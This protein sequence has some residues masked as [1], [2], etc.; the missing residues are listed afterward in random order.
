MKS[1]GIL[2]ES[3]GN[4][5]RQRVNPDAFFSTG[6]EH[7]LQTDKKKII[8]RALDENRDCLMEHECKELL[9]SIGIKTA[10][11]IIAESED[12]A[13]EKSRRIGYP[14]A[15]KI[16][17]P[18]VTHKSDGGGVKLNVEN[19]EG[20]RKAYHEI[21][22][23][24]RHC[25]VIGVS[26]QKMADPGLEAIIGVTRDPGFGPVLMF[27]LG[28]VFV[29]VLKD[30]TFRILPIDE[31][32]AAEM[33][34]EIKGSP[35]L[36]GY[37]GHAADI[38][39]LKGL[40][41]KISRLI[42]EHPEIRELD[43]NPVFLYPSGC[44]AVDARIYVDDLQMES[45]EAVS[46]GSGVSYDFFYPRSI[47]V[48]GATDSIGKL[49]YNVFHNLIHHG[50][51][52]N[53][54]PINPK[55]ETV[56]GVKAYKSILD[57]ED[58]VDT[59]IV[60]VPAGTVPQAIEDCCTKGIKYLVIETAGFA[61]I[62]EEGKQ[63]QARIKE[64]IRERGCRLLGPNCSGVINTHHNMVQSIGILDTL[65]KG[66]VGLIAQA[67]VY[68]AGILAGLRH[69]LDFGIVATIGNKMDISETDILEFMGDDKH[70][71][72][73]AMYMEDVTSGKRF[74]NV[75]SRVSQRKPVVVLKTGRTEAGKKAV[76][77]HT[78]SLA[79]NDEINSAAFRQSGIIR[80]RDNEH[81][82]ALMR[83]FSKQPLPKGPGVLVIT[84]TG[85]LGVAATD[86]LYLNN[87][88]LSRF[89]PYLK[90]RL[91]SILPDYL[92][93]QNPV[94]CSFSMTPEQLKS[95]IEIGI[96][97]KDVHSIIVIV[98]GEKLA[99]FVDTMKGIDYMGKPVVCCVACK[100]FMIDNVI[101]M[102]QAGIPVY[103]TSEMAA[104]VLG[105]MYR[106]GQRRRNTLL[107]ALDRCLADKSF[108][109][110]DK[111]VRFRL[112][113]ASDIDLWAD[114]V[115]GCSQQS[116]W[117]RFLSPFSV[118]PERALR[119]CDI[120]PDEECAIIAEMI[121][122]DHRKV[123]GIARLIR[124]SHNNEAEFA[125]IISDPWQKRT[126]G[127]MLSEM[128]VGL[129]KHWGVINVVSET[130]QENHAMMKI[131]K[132]CRFNVENKNGN[133]FTMSLKL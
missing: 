85:S 1:S 2:R 14:V 18:D 45:P 77:S 50:F 55:K 108:T 98:Q 40:L 103:S 128:S 91:T 7:L 69:V 113:R 59:A 11:G 132:R 94:D 65:R 124:L 29:E 125:V 8:R 17:S 6:L 33:I 116:L 52:G 64:I 53:L 21:V 46:P 15:L 16:V 118:T 13:V 71:D 42:A 119:F 100:E 123:I 44:L 36:K 66:N 39:S 92:N 79:G 25:T 117:L 102:E 80:A 24:F 23:A 127:Q 86:M 27:G 104:E 22:D 70:I 130:V 110:D 10:R 62:G 107:K 99:S 58:P 57:V 28:G 26:V 67:G 133:M 49:G 63:A 3:Q 105:E 35:L 47:A 9:E 131:L 115:N 121:D 106:Y 61:E 126:L 74:I 95:I 56:L 43:L 90:E 122:G 112:L 12:D 72:V 93:I 101:R 31:D 51:H 73:I 20:V 5:T 111:P 120:H 60:I 82:F 89:E 4:I 96:L 48:L 88:K 129:A 32:D 19:D 83:G 81:L 34:G 87:L 78:A 109:I 114:F 97:S 75:A 76:S 41:L 84:Y 54:Y 38:E 68:A 37:R 30:V